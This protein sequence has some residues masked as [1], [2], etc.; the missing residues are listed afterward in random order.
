MKR[1]PG[2]IA[3]GGIGAVVVFGGC[4]L[5]PF[6]AGEAGLKPFAHLGKA[7]AKPQAIN[8]EENSK[9]SSKK[10]LEAA[11][12]AKRLAKARGGAR[13]EAWMA[14][15]PELEDLGNGSLKYV[16][17]MDRKPAEDDP[18]KLMSG[19]AEI[20]FKYAHDNVTLSTLNP[21][22]ITD[23]ESWHFDGRE[24]KTWEPGHVD[25]VR[26]TVTFDVTDVADIRPGRT[27]WW[28]RNISADVALGKGDTGSFVLNALDDVNHTQSGE[29]HFYD[30]HTGRDNNG[31]PYAFD[32]ELVVYHKNEQDPGKPYYRYE[33]NEGLLT[34]T[35][36]WAET[37]DDLYYWIYFSRVDMAGG[38]IDYK[39][40]G[41][42]YK[43][44]ENGP[45]LAEFIAY[46]K[47]SKPGY[48]IYYN[49]SGEEIGR[50]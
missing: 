38:G 21:A 47:G 7:L 43:N 32:F 23:I 46:E 44:S 50:E 49:E 3:A 45:L 48:V 24:E 40:T 20:V 27:E 12:S 42:I 8:E 2:V 15:E 5:N 9:Q 29:G 34:F 26:A 28:G 18:Q 37:G 33:D 41:K 25:S 1:I 35:L 6:G 22:L 36:P 10:R 11:G 19:T 16:E 39:R 14:A 4:G 17:Y 31:E 13:A 30:A